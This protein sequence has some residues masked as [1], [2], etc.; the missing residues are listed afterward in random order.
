MVV[1]N[2]AVRFAQIDFEAD[3]H[4]A[5]FAQYREA[6]NNWLRR[7]HTA[8]KWI[9]PATVIPGLAGSFVLIGAFIRA[10]VRL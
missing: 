6:H 7:V 8:W 5:V 3:D 2:L 1:S 10:L 4:V 9:Y